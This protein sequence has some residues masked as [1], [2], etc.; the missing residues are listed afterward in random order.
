MRDKAAVNVGRRHPARLRFARDLRM[1]LARA[2]PPVVAAKGGRKLGPRE[3][4]Y[5]RRQL[6][7]FVEPWHHVPHYEIAVLL[8]CL[9]R[10]R[11][12]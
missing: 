10:G 5:A 6:A 12:G 7:P 1:P 2:S 11:R 4:V 8:I 9:A 3:P